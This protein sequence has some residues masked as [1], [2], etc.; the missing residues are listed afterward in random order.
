[1]LTRTLYMGGKL[2]K[3]KTTALVIALLM[4]L[5]LIAGCT[6]KRPEFVADK[7]K[8]GDWALSLD[9]PVDIDFAQPD[10]V[11]VPASSFTV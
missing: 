5:G 9:G 2:M 4:L 11:C 6:L 3:R 10:T 8:E 1:M 7:T